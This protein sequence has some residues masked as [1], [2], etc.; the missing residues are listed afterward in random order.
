MPENTEYMILGYAITIFILISI[1]GYLV[2]KAR[3]LHAELTTLQRLEAEDRPIEQ[4]VTARE[5]LPLREPVT[6]HAER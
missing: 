5:A 1:V 2:L 3:N 4:P 6:R